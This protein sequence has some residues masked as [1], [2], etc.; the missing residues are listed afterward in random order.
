M[1][2]LRQRMTEELRLRGY[3][4]RT[5]KAYVQQACRFVRSVGRDPRQVEMERFDGT[6][7][8]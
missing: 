4:P 7:W 5:T 3:S 6:W 8:G 2:E 1:G